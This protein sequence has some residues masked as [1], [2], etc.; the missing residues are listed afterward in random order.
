MVLLLTVKLTPLLAQLDTVNQESRFE[1]PLRCFPSL[2]ML[3]GDV[4]VAPPAAKYSDAGAS[5]VCT[6]VSDSVVCSTWV[7]HGLRLKA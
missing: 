5:D 1:S 7:G 4:T 6:A 2:A 3:A